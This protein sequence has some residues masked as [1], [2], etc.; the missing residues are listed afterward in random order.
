MMTIITIITIIIIIIIIMV[1]GVV[2]GDRAG[3]YVSPAASWRG[4]S[5][6]RYRRRLLNV[7]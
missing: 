2:V 6:S 5:P 3:E 4:V 1:P 7:S